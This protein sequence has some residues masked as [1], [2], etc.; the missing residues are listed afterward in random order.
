M[1]QLKQRLLRLGGG[2]LTVAAALAEIEARI[3]RLVGTE[4]VP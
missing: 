2:L 1:A 4:T 3:P